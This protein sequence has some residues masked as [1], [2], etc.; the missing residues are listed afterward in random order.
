MQ[1]DGR[2]TF[3]HHQEARNDEAIKATYERNHG[4][5]APKLLTT[6]YSYVDF[7]NPF[8]KLCLS[9]SSMN[10]CV[11]GYDFDLTVTGEIKFKF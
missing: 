5:K 7:N 9:P 2:I 11:E 3:K 6:G 1:S 8:P 4:E 10:M